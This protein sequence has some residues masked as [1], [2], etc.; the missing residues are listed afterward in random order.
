M[1]VR[2][3]FD[4]QYASTVPTSRQY[5]SRSC[6]ERT[7]EFEKRCA[8]ALPFWTIQGMRSLPKSW[9]ESSSAASRFSSSKRFSV[10]NT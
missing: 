9:V 5:A 4:S 2:S 8:T 3:M 1:S 7:Q 6:V 10:L